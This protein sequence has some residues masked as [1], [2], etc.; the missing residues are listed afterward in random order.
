MSAS[1]SVSIMDGRTAVGGRRFSNMSNL[2]RSLPGSTLASQSI[3]GLSQRSGAGRGGGGGSLELTSL[4]ENLLSAVTSGDVRKGVEKRVRRTRSAVET[5]SL[6]VNEPSPGIVPIAESSP[7]APASASSSSHR[8]HRSKEPP[9]KPP[10][11]HKPSCSSSSVI[12]NGRF[13]GGGGGDERLDR[14]RFW[15]SDSDSDLN[16]RQKRRM[17]HHDSS[18]LSPDGRRGLDAADDASTEASGS[19]WKSCLSQ[20][21][22]CES[23]F[24]KDNSMDTAMV[25]PLTHALF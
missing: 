17:Q 15:R 25:F 2:A 18:S 7:V 1:I 16:S 3:V 10:R 8:G 12:N 20:L 6:A 21:Y 19:P 23:Y 14:R 24:L 22:F 5:C 4:N 9:P 11:L 13:A